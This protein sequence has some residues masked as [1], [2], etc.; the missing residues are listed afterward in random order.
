M[1]IGCHLM[2]KMNNTSF[3]RAGIPMPAEC[4]SLR[5][6]FALLFYKIIKM[7]MPNN[8]DTMTLSCSKTT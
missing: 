7:A 6:Y 4:C 8:I 2:K 5:S 3:I 1:T